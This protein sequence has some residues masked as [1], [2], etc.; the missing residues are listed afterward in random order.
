MLLRDGAVYIVAR[1]VPSTLGFVTATL[2]TWIL[3]PDA[4]GLYGLGMAAVLLGSNALFDWLSL[5]LMRW[6]QT[7][8]QD[9]VFL[10][11]VLSIFGA[12]CLGSA[13]LLAVATAVGLTGG[14]A[15]EAWLFLAGTWA[16][17]WFEFASRFQIGN[18]RPWR[19]LAMNVA[20]NIG[21]LAGS[22]AAASLTHAAEPVLAISFL[23]MAVGGCFFA[24]DG[25][26]RWR[27]VFD[28]PL[29]RSLV[30]FG[31]PMGLTMILF[32]LTTSINRVM[33][34]ALSTDAAVGAFT[35][36]FTLVQ[37]SIGVI[38]VGIGAASYS[39]AV[40]AVESGDAA[41]AQVQLCRNYSVLLALLL[42]SGIG[43]ALL[44]PR[45]ATLL[46]SP[47]YHEAIVLATPWLAATAI[48][49]GLRANYVDTA[50]QLGKRPGLLAQVM[51]VSATVNVVLGFALIPRF[52][53]LGACA[54]MCLAFTVAFVH[55]SL[56]ARRAYPLPFPR[57]ETAR[58]AL[59][60]AAMVAV[61]IATRS[62]PGLTGL[63]SGIVLASGVYAAAA[64]TL[65]ILGLRDSTR[66]RWDALRVT[67]A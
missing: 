13:A 59:A 63:A 46:I 49:M 31:A 41:A 37:N 61:L 30:A 47:A 58:I 51:G 66:E 12:I 5:S 42:P 57:S 7:H 10:S 48:L 16:Y 19:Y 23:A 14:H 4:Y 67:S 9:T 32:G 1:I 45:I 44:A 34:G 40:R 43:L 22:F 62:W 33:L 11:T 38:A 6:Y 56:L 28:W 18:F 52:S 54:A 36:A 64:V 24:A 27:P 60:T 17:A 65:N 53:Y 20:R 39:A 55:A 2:L 50:F 3:P 26:L 35:I 8:G 29:A 15:R 25:P 21:I